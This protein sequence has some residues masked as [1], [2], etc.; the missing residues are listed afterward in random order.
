VNGPGAGA[1]INGL[2]AP[3]TA[4]HA[5]ATWLSARRHLALVNGVDVAITLSTLATAL[6]AMVALIVILLSGA[7]ERGRSLA[8]VRTL[9]LP[10]RLGWWLALA[11]VAPLLVAA[12]I[13]GV[14]AGVGIVVFLEPAMG[15]RELAG[16]LGDPQP[17]VS[18]SLIAGLAASTIVLLLIAIAI[19]VAV[20]RRDRLNDVLRVGE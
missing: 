3:R 7:R 5:R 12:I 10:A 8:L 14:L 16:G 19:E 18:P 2:D 20:R 6:A 17:T 13:G 11:E 1:A 15:L 9:G 4:V